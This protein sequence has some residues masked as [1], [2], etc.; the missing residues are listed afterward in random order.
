MANGV[1][2]EDTQRHRVD[3]PIFYGDFLHLLD[4]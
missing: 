1:D 2:E 4:N 3:G